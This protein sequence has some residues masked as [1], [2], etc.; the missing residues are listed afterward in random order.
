M[1]LLHEITIPETALYAVNFT[2]EMLYYAAEDAVM[3]VSYT[4]K[5]R[6][7]CEL[8]GL[9][10][11]QLHCNISELFFVGKATDASCY[12]RIPMSSKEI[13]YQTRDDGGTDL[14]P[15]PFD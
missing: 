14:L 4:G 5:E 12:G 9:T 6:L 11:T 15:P 2:D 3:Q 8:N 10:L 13:T 1:E 7:C